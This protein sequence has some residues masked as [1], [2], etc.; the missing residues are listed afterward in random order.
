MPDMR[1]T[2]TIGRSE[3]I[4]SHPVRER[5]GALAASKNFETGTWTR[6]GKK[7][8]TVMIKNVQTEAGKA[9]PPLL[10]KASALLRFGEHRY[11]LR[12]RKAL[13]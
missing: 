13:T 6:R 11:V 3:D 12:E 7:S 2:M 8:K 9:P 10:C 4:A 5:G 1:A